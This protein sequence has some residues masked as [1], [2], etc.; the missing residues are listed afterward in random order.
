MDLPRNIVDVMTLY[1][2]A[3]E[4]EAETY[5]QLSFY[6]ALLA[7]IELKV[8]EQIINEHKSYNSLG[9]T[10]AERQRVIQTALMRNPEW[11]S[12]DSEVVTSRN[13]HKLAQ[14]KLRAYDLY[15]QYLIAYERGTRRRE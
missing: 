15:I 3:A 9:K 13:Q 4:E 7:S 8:T 1:E 5:K 12:T 11:Y 2:K 6:K 14:A 10:E